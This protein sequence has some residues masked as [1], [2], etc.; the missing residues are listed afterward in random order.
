MA[1]PGIETLTELIR[2][3]AERRGMDI[4]EVRTVKA[5]KKSQV[6]V[7]L[8]SDTRPTLDELEEVSNEIS[9][10]F[11]AHEAAGELNFGAGYTLEVT[12]PGVD[13]PLTQPRHWRRNRGRKVKVG[14]ATYRVGA[15]DEEERTVVLIAPASGG[16]TV[17]LWPVSD[18]AGAVV[19]VEFSNPPAG[20]IELAE[21][22]FDE[23]AA[24]ASHGEGE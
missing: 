5:G 16:P 18:L 19:E 22:S 23:A 4:E 24:A 9:E 6:V 2:P 20:E 3:L 13:L 10:L 17:E 15:L 21:Q 7:A 11:D 8:D 1:F 12:T 14:E